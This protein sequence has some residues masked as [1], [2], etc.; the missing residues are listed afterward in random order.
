MTA[1]VVAVVAVAVGV[2]SLMA[3]RSDRSV[4]VGS[5]PS[6]TD[7][8][9][10]PARERPHGNSIDFTAAEGT[11]TLTLLD[12]HWT[13]TGSAAPASGNYLVVHLRLTA[14][15]GSVRSDPYY[16]HSFDAA[17]GLYDAA[18]DADLD[19]GLPAATLNAGRSVTGYLAF[20]MPRGFAQLVM[21][22]DQSETVTGLKVSA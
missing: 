9:P 6:P 11:G 13:P 16:F 10:V 8:G 1:L 22:D 12:Y 7:A 15:T 19:P 14:R 4:S 20:D 17:G 21:G 5:A 18:D 2:G 3:Y